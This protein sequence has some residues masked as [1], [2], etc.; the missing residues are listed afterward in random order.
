MTIGSACVSALL[1]HAAPAN[2]AGAALQVRTNARAV[3]DS[4]LAA[5]RAFSAA[6]RTAPFPQALERMFTAGAMMPLRDSV[7]A[8]RSRLVQL[9]SA[10]PDSQARVTWT[11]VRVGLSADAQHGF[12]A[13]F[14]MASRPTGQR[15][16]YKYLAYW[17]R[18]GD[19]WRVAAWRRRPM[20]TTAAMDSSMLD[21]V[22]PAKLV[23]PHGDP[24]R[25]SRDRHALMDAEQGFSDLANRIG[26]GAAFAE[27]GAPHALN[28]GA[29]NEGR[30]TVGNERIAQLVAGGQA[31][32]APSSI[33]WRADT[34]LVASSGDFGITFG[35]IRPKIPPAQGPAGA[36]FFTIWQKSPAG[37]WRY[38]AE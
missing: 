24:V 12:T 13:G 22:L 38:I 1:R 23:S 3:A 6:S 30:F 29:F 5:D 31:L 27:L 33:T 36:A 26:V 32:S 37:A 9:L 17:V 8:G 19:A 18:E 15:A 28:I 34:A 20:D 35:V 7:I 11:P 2:A 4:L 25:L 14:M 16:R 21:P 10:S